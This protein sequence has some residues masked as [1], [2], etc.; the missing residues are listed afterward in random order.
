MT[1]LKI[2]EPDTTLVTN[3]V[4]DQTSSE[5]KPWKFYNDATVPR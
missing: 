5:Q 2:D 1:E 3:F 4:Y